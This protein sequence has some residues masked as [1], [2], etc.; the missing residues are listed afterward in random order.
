MRNHMHGGGLSSLLPKAVPVR[1]DETQ[2]DYSAKIQ[3]EWLN[4]QRRIKAYSLRAE[5]SR[6]LFDPPLTPDDLTDV[7]IGLLEEVE[8]KADRATRP[9]GG[10]AA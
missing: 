10:E 5:A 6:P 9:R 7:D 1:L 2:E 4:K 3:C 8:A